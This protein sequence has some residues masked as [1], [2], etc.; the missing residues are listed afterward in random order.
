M[1]TGDVTLYAEWQGTVAYNA[2]SATSGSVP[3]SVTVYANGSDITLSTNTGTLARTGYTFTGW[4]TS[5]DGTGT[6]YDTG[7]SYQ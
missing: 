4:N 5:N 6:H 3:S 7:S 1:V 2:N